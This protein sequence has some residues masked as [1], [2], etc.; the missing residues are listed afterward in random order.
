MNIAIIFQ[1][2]NGIM[3]NN[4]INNEGT[5]ERRREESQLALGE[6]QDDCG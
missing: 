4:V 1:K 6:K 5:R 3:M 2:S